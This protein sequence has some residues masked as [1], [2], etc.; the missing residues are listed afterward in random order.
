MGAGM[1]LSISNAFSTFH[2]VPDTKQSEDLSSKMTYFYPQ[3]KVS[4]LK[5]TRHSQVMR[6]KTR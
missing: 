3:I 4:V 2:P 5:Y 6:E 1:N